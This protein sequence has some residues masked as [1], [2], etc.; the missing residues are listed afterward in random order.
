MP[1]LS[2]RS[3]LLKSH[4]FLKKIFNK[5]SLR[6]ENS[7]LIKKGATLTLGACLLIVWEA[8]FIRSSY[9]PAFETL[10][11]NDLSDIISDIR[12][13][14]EA[15]FDLQQR[16]PEDFSDFEEITSEISM[17]REGINARQDAINK[18]MHVLTPLH[19]E[20]TLKAQEAK[21]KFLQCARTNCKHLVKLM[22]QSIDAAKEAEVHKKPYEKVREVNE[23]LKKLKE[24]LNNI[25]KKFEAKKQSL[26]MGT[27]PPSAS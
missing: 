6:I 16:N 14:E 2:F 9:L 11:E 12:E 18:E 8:L 21:G 19:E 27:T 5:A 20:S 24:S 25:E 17:L 7:L 26:E 3:V 4:A 22:D 13:W 23:K 10:Q 15:A 1:F